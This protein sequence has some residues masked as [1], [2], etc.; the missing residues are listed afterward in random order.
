VINTNVRPEHTGGNQ[1]VAKT[2]R[3]FGGRAAGAGF[4]APEPSEGATIIAH[5]NVLTRMSAPTGNQAP[6]P[7]AAWP[8]ETYFNEEYE[9]FNGEAVQLYHVPRANTDGDSL[10]FFRRSDVIAAGD[11]FSTESY[12]IIDEQSGGSINGVIA[13]LNLI[14][15]LAIPKATEEGGTYVIPSH[16]RV[17]DEADVVEYR[18]MVVIIRDRVEDLMKKGMTLAQVKA[19]R[20]TFDYDRRYSTESYT[21]EMFIE[22]VYRGLNRK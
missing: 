22:A 13:A 17:S 6:T 2:G 10:V 16:G 1:N 19:A 5:E 21:A 20:P 11:V 7:F 14:L 4:L 3:A 15:D 8:T 12:P 18:D 9:L